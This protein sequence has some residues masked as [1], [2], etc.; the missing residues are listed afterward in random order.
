[1]ALTLNKIG[2]ENGPKKQNSYFSS[3][4]RPWSKESLIPLPLIHVFKPNEIK[5]LRLRERMTQSV[6]VEFLNLDLSTIEK[7]ETGD[8]QPAGAA[9]RLLSLLDARGLKAFG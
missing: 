6:F 2:L 3:D 4:A 9:L 5:E 7:W 8:I 1:M